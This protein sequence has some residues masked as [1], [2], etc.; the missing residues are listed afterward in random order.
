[1]NSTPSAKFPVDTSLLHKYYDIENKQVE[2]IAEGGYASLYRVGDFVLR[3]SKDTKQVAQ[4][5]DT[6]RRVAGKNSRIAVQ[7]AILTKNGE[8]HITVAN[9]VWRLTPYS[10]GRIVDT[11]ELDSS[12]LHN[13]AV[14]LA[15]FHNAMAE[16]SK[17][18][19][20]PPPDYTHLPIVHLPNILFARERMEAM[21]KKL[22]PSSASSKTQKEHIDYI[23]SHR[24][25][26]LSQF[27]I[28]IG[29]VTQYLPS[30]P[31]T[32][33]HGDYWKNNILFRPDGSV[34]QIVDFG[35]SGRAPRID[36]LI[37][38]MLEK[39]NKRPDSEKIAL[40]LTAYQKAA[41]TK[42]SD[43]EQRLI[44]EQFRRFSL[45]EIFYELYTWTTTS[46]YSFDSIEKRVA[47]LR[48]LDAFP[49]V[50]DE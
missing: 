3:I 37:G 23:L 5:E 1:M 19:S 50:F 38:P 7:D 21:F 12:H 40:F 15:H 20:L 24:D 33:I 10:E 45:Q 22:N 9:T 36:D 43:I 17:D 2:H 42:L 6:I 35:M 39:G 29:S 32:V 11:S 46:N 25:F 48:V 4:L 30:L 49:S 28:L 16:L 47:S 44:K 27:V 8:R 14:E 26:I 18:P 41:S 31:I 34:A 13:A